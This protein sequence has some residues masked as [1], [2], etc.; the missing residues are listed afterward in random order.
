[1]QISF[2]T[3]FA[4]VALGVVAIIAAI[5]GGV[6]A[7]HRGDPYLFA[8]FMAGGSAGI[9]LVVIGLLHKD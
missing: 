6:A 7:T 8:F 4:F 2:S 1:M 3:S 5:G 9:S